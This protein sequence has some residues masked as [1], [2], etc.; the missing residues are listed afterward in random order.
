MHRA[1]RPGRRCVVAGA[2]VRG[3]ARRVAQRARMR[4]PG[5]GVADLGR[6]AHPHDPP[7]GVLEQ[8]EHA[9][10]RR[11]RW[12]TRPPARTSGAARPGCRVVLV[13]VDEHREARACAPRGPGR[14]ASDAAGS[15]STCAGGAAAPASSSRAR[16]SSS[17]RSPPGMRYPPSYAAPAM[18]AALGVGD[19]RAAHPEA[20]ARAGARRS[21]RRPRCPARSRSSR[22]SSCSRRSADTRGR[23]DERRVEQDAR[24]GVAALLLLAHHQLAAPGGGRPVHAAQRVAVA[25][26]AG[27]ELVG[28]RVRAPLQAVHARR[29]SLAAVPSAASSGGHPRGHDDLVRACPRRGRSGRGRTGRSMPTRSGPDRVDAAPRHPEPVLE[30]HR[31][32]ARRAARPRTARSPGRI[33]SGG[34]GEAVGHA[35]A[36]VRAVEGAPRR[37]SSR[38]ATPG[39]SAPAA[40][41]GGRERAGHGEARRAQ[42]PRRR[43]AA[44]G[45]RDADE[46]EQQ[47]VAQVEP[48]RH[49]EEQRPRRP[50]ACRRAW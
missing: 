47:D 19:L 20:R 33:A 40:T 5:P 18:T 3:A 4:D 23:P 25:V 44:D 29:R 7:V 45:H 1:H 24:L 13:G 10:A 32:V 48:Q 41:T 15:G 49:R 50:R 28:V 16:S 12:R 38:R 42:P 11:P 30:A 26:L 9:R 6:P 8:V 34:A 36:P 22:P 31:V 43:A 14:R 27:D 35:V 37:G 21:R 17:V 39:S 46:G 2:P